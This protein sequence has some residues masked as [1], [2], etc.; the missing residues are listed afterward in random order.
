MTDATAD[1]ERIRRRVFPPVVLGD[2]ITAL[3]VVRS[4]GGAGLEPM[5]ASPLR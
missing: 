3:G 2:G 5:L 1:L 4:L